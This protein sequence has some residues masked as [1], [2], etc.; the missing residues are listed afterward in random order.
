MEGIYKQVLDKMIEDVDSLVEELN[1]NPLFEKIKQKKKL[2]NDFSL[3]HDG[4]TIYQDVES[5]KLIKNIYPGKYK[6]MT[7]AKA[8]RDYL[9]MRGKENPP[10][11]ADILDA[12]KKGDFDTKK[13]SD[14]RSALLKNNQ[15]NLLRGDYFGLAEWYDK[16][17]KKSLKENSEEQS[18]LEDDNKETDEQNPEADNNDVVKSQNYENGKIYL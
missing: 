2:I 18:V 14:I 10:T 16:G 12:L 11:Y 17:K 15:V 3:A 13:I 5:E 8:V 6:G 7:L 9:S 1:K 4:D